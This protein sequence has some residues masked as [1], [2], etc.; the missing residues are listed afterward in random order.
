MYLS[1][2]F[3]SKC[4]ANWHKLNDKRKEG[5][6]A[7]DSPIVMGMDAG[8]ITFMFGVSVLF[9]FLE[10]VL[11][12]YAI[13]IVMKCTNPGPERFVHFTLAVMFTAPY[14]LF[15]MTFNKC[16]KT[17]WQEYYDPNTS[18]SAIDMQKGV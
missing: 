10:L 4:R 17:S 11:F 12:F 8:A 9:V 7:K 2:N 5:F 14:M 18:S 1:L 6:N 16:A 3:F 15:Q 13:S